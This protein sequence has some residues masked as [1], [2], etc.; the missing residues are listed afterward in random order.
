MRK[1]IHYLTFSLA[2][3]LYAIPMAANAESYGL[4]FPDGTTI[5]NGSRTLTSVCLTSPSDGTQTIES[6]QASDRLLFHD[7]TGFCFSAAAG[8]TVTVTFNWSGTWMHGYVYIDVDNDGTFNASSGTDKDVMSYSNYDGSNSVGANTAN[9][10][11]GVNPP[12]FT[13]PDLPTGLYRMRTKVDWNAIDPGGSTKDGNTITANGGAIT[14]MMIYIHQPGGSF[15]VEA[16]NGKLTDESG[17]ELTAASATAGRDLTVVPHPDEGYAFD[18]L[19]ISSG[20]DCGN[21]AVTF[22]NAAMGK[23]THSVPAFA[24]KNGA[25]TIPASMLKGDVDIVATFLTATASA[26]GNYEAD[27]VGDKDSAKGIISLTVNGETKTVTSASRHAFLGDKA[28]AVEIGK[29]FVLTADYSGSATPLKFYLDHGQDGAFTEVKGGISS[30]L[31]GELKGDC[32]FTVNPML[33]AG[34][35]RARLVAPGDCTVD[36]LINLHNAAGALDVKALNGNVLGSDGSALPLT[37]DFGTNLGIKPM[38]VLPGFTAS[39]I[40]VRHGHNLNGPNFVRGNRQ[41]EDTTLPIKVGTIPAELVDGDVDIYV[42]Y[43]E[44]ANGQWTK[45]WGDEFNGSELDPKRWKYQ[46]RQSPTWKRLIAQGDEIPYTNKVED[47]HYK[48]YCIPTPDEFKATETQPMIS[49]AINSSGLFHLTY[50]RIEARIK[51]TRHTG[52]FPAFWMMPQD[53]SK[54]WPN[55]GEIDIWEQIDESQTT[56]HTVHSGWTKKTLGDVAMSSPTSGGT[57]W[58][59]HDLWHVIALEWDA[60]QLRWYVD[61]DQKFTYNNSHYSYGDYTEDITWPFGKDFYIIL[62]QSVGDGSWAKP[63]DTS[64]TYLTEFDWVRVYKKKDD[65]GFTTSID[66]NGDDPDFYVA[67]EDDPLTSITDVR[68]DEMNSEATAAVEYFDVRGIRVL[69]PST[70]GLYICRQGSKTTKILKH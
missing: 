60:E 3:C 19:Q 13:V 64:F 36:F 2:L 34:V 55:C 27:T 32:T 57:G 42:I 56:Y 67:G 37:I 12:A 52:N 39:E 63:L 20:Y 9:G 46:D 8:E 15:S 48:A 38:T 66:G 28:F 41:W 31:L 49:G 1:P 4:N 30:D 62:N 17:V 54:G 59:D 53:Q 68:S 50:G 7:R 45:V 16:E 47:G 23:T 18:A 6:S 26:S 29:P 21:P 5:T 35:Y 44:T 22:A 70:P 69:S 14:D 40:I 24:L 58:A 51:T 65:K 10:N 43:S 25:V 61:G 33:P 11:V